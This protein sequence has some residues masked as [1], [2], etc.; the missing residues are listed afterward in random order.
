MVWRGALAVACLG[1]ACQVP[2]QVVPLHLEAGTRVFV[3]GREVPAVSRSIELR[4]DRPHVVYLQRTGYHAQQ[5]IL[6]TRQTAAGPA[7]EPDEIRVRLEPVLP[8]ARRIRIE[9][10]D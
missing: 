5:L 4:S 8:T 1:I 3:D 9:E 2:T 10:A 6:T 7:L